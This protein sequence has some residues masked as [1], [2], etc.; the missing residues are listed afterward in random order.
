MFFTRTAAIITGLAKEW[1][2]FV[3]RTQ[4]ETNADRHSNCVI[5]NPAT[6]QCEC[7]CQRTKRAR[8]GTNR[9]CSNQSRPQR[10]SFTKETGLCAFSEPWTGCPE[11]HGEPHQTTFSHP[12]GIRNGKGSKAA[13]YS[14]H[15]WCTKPTDKCANP[16]DKCTDPDSD[17]VIH[18]CVDTNCDAIDSSSHSNE[19]E[20]EPATAPNPCSQQCI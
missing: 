7:G 18:S 11:V 4:T 2:H 15:D 10:P 16:T 6:K 8:T 1:K 12:C 14:Q 19:L 9:S 5:L 17:S 3:N 13:E 20:P